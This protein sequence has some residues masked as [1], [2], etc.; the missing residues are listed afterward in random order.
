M[1]ILFVRPRYEGGFGMKPI[2]VAMLSAIAKRAGFQTSLFDIGYT[3]HEFDTYN[4]LEKLRSVN[5]VAPVDFSSYNFTKIKAPLE[6]TVIEVL[7]RRKPDIVAFSVISGQHILAEKVSRY[8]KKYN[9]KITIIWGGAY[10]TIS[11]E[12]ALQQ[13]ADYVCVGEG[14][15]A[16]ENFLTAFA[17]K[18]DL[19][20]LS[21]I[22]TKRNN[23]IIRNKL[24]PMKESL[25]DLP[26]L[27]WSIFDA[28]DFLKPFDGKIL[29]GGDYMIT[30]GCPNKCSYCI[31]A[32]CQKLYKKEGHLFKLKRYSIDRAIVELKY[33][34]NKYNLEFFKFCDE[35]FLLVS[36]SFLQEFVDK[37]KK[38]IGL[39][40]TT[41][42]HPKVITDEKIKLL[43]EA[44]CV[45]LSIGI[46]S[47]DT[48][49][50]KHVLNRS[51][52]V[53]DIVRAF[54]LAKTVGIRTMSFN[55][56]GTPFYTTDLYEKTIELN[57]RAGVSN[58]TISFFY[59]FKGTK[60]RE[61]AIDN[62]FYK[63]E[64]DIVNPI[65]KIGEPSLTF[66]NLS[67]KKLKN[68]FNTFADRVRSVDID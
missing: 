29:R 1:N 47:G 34:K 8:I 37:Y 11:P 10:T 2:G 63:E 45:S 65:M 58:P 5:V 32:Y 67:K 46:E 19:Y 28:R 56:I 50:R 48:E 23:K 20:Q 55:M 27:D 16:F 66:K 49:Y 6:N 12:E 59:P 21:N 13:G 53:E 41:A 14:L 51:D 60:L 68:M 30:W 57:R 31:N 35:N 39:P 33:L 22:W 15:L 26:Y 61:I 42:C 62:N 64:N 40:F 24:I 43:K 44:G 18:D 54:T 3:E 36:I 17:A 25:D 9:S 52:S 7:K 38:E 4:Y